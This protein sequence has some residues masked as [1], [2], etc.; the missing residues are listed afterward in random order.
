[1]SFASWQRCRIITVA[2]A[3]AS[4]LVFSIPAAYAVPSTPEIEQKQAQA[5]AANAELESMRADLEVQVEEYNAITEAVAATREEIRIAHEELEAA[6]RRL[7]TAQ[8][9]LGDRAANIYRSGGTSAIEFLLGVQSFD[10]LIVRF[11][12]M[13]RIN[14][15]D[16]VAVADVKD[17]KAR[18]EATTEALE[19]RQAEQVALQTQ[20]EVRA[21]AIEEEIARQERFVARLDADVQTLIAEEEE[22][23]RELEAERAR[24]AAEAAA[25]RRAAE[26]AASGSAGGGTSAGRDAAD[27][28]SL[29][30]GNASVVDIALQYLG[31][32]Y[33][34]GGASPAG[35]DCSGLMQYSYRQ[36]GV[37]LPRTSRAQYAVGQHIAPD[38]LDLLQPGDLVF[39]GTG[40]DPSRV[41]HV[42]MYV[43]DGNY[44]HAPYTG[45]VVRIDSLTGRITRSQDYVGASRL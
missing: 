44:L 27:P 14:S 41:H 11:E 38:R 42:G 25:A 37:M 39:F 24:Q 30:S 8:T 33:V 6:R 19:Q 21:S 31:V 36:V 43:G 45:A 4:S 7:A 5:D 32:P 15:A 20:A 40:G 29:G 35:F 17:A 1:M 18:V 22:R 2:L 12:L 28:G 23:L 16:A 34:W 13:R 10:D 3:V 9:A 26:A